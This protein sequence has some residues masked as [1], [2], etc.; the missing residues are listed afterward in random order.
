L[1]NLN[2]TLQEVLMNFLLNRVIPQ[3]SRAGL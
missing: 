1:R 3:S 2:G